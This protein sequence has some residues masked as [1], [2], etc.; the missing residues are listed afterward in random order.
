MLGGGQDVSVPRISLCLM[1]TNKPQ[2][3]H[4]KVNN[5]Q[6]NDTQGLAKKNALWQYNLSEIV[7]KSEM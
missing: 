2:W 7:S 5:M 6:I 1:E 3:A 4:D